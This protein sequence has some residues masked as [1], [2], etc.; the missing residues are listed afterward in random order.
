[1]SA[2]ELGPPVDFVPAREPGGEVLRGQYVRLEPLDPR[3]HAEGLWAAAQGGDPRLWDYLPYGPFADEGAFATWLSTLPGLAP[4]ERF[5]AIV[6]EAT[7]APAGMIAYA[8]IA[9]ERGR[10]EIA[11]VWFGAALQRTPGATE[12]V[13]LLAHHA[14][15]DLGNRRLEWKCHSLNARSRRAAERFGF[16]Y[17][18]TFRQDLVVK[19]R[20]RDTAWFS[21]LDAEW[22]T[23]DAAFRAWLAPENFDADG[24]QRRGLAE[25]RAG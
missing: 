6:A 9:P 19:G 11:H 4:E 1:M 5:Y 13:Y 20:N 23:A 12:A 25:L 3:G 21:L 17:E 24:R 18:G 14:F 8:R 10:T 15:A 7:G 2:A 22:P 16:T